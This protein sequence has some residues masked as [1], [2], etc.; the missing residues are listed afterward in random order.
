MLLY[1]GW[2]YLQ[3]LQLVHHNPGN[4]ALIEERR[5]A[6]RAAGESDR[7]RQQWVPMARISPY[8]QHALIV[9]EDATFY[10]HEGFDW[11]GIKVAAEKNLREGRVVAGGSTITQQLAKNLFLSTKRTP[12]RKAQEA[13]ITVMLEKTLGKRRIFEIYLN[14]IEWGNGVFGAQA[15]ARH[16]FGTDASRLTP[17]EAAKLASMV[18]DPRFYDD[19][20]GNRHLLRKTRVILARMK[21]RYG[22]NFAAQPRVIKAPLPRRAADTELALPQ[23]NEGAVA[24]E[25]VQPPD[26]VPSPAPAGEPSPGAETQSAQRI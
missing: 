4:T 16:Y 5:Q 15:A 2:L 25:N 17:R 8:L 20:P 10:G 9:S 23:D 6:L 26:T 13:L 14:V 3:V 1:E 22:S 12:W 18:P 24:P 7:I 11:E 21:L 19:H